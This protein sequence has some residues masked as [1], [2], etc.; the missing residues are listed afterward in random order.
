MKILPGPDLGF[1]G[2]TLMRKQKQNKMHNTPWNWLQFTER[3]ILSGLLRLWKLDKTRPK[4]NP[5]LL[6]QAAFIRYNVYM[7]E[8]HTNNAE[9]LEWLYPWTQHP[10]GGWRSLLCPSPWFL[11]NHSRVL[12]KALG[13]HLTVG[14]ISFNLWVSLFLTFHTAYS[15][16]GREWNLWNY[17]EKF[18]KCSP[19]KHAL[20][21]LLPLPS[22][23]IFMVSIRNDITF[24]ELKGWC[25]SLCA[26]F[27]LQQG[28]LSFPGGSVIKNPPAM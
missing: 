23:W 27:D 26:S 19:A 12:D 11:C 8:H 9:F 28:A 20:S 13:P 1:G 16:D 14:F 4:V 10:G 3:W 25:C 2:S 18:A 5:W 24:F 21:N 17:E 15:Y 7:F 6:V 22:P